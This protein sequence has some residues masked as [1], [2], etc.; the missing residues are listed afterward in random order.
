MYRKRFGLHDHPLP[1]DACGSSFYEGGDAFA[2]LRRVFHWLADEPGLAILTGDAGV[3]KTAALRHLCSTLP[4]PEHRVL[5]ICDTQV[6]ATAL[7][8]NL[9]VE[10]GLRPAH[11]RDALWRDLKRTMLQLVDEQNVIPMLILD[12]AQHLPDEFFADLAGFLNYAFDS[13][14]LLTVWL[15]GLPS[16][17]HRLAM[18]QHAA[19]ATRIVSANRIPARTDREDFFAMIE[20]AMAAAGAT[21]R[22]LSDPALELLWRA[23]RGLPR[24]AAKILRS[25]L[26]LAH[27]RDHS[28]VDDSLVNAAIDD[29][30]LEH[31][32]TAPTPP[33]APGQKSRRKTETSSRR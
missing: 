25:S 1:R 20:S 22:L 30:A 6:S 18:R 12:E 15:V 3:G 11:R 8:R 4:R 33:P 13:R 10:L 31:P 17:D 29:L 32:T 9:A 28:F 7:Y 27:E 23:S 2:R 21:T 19:L 14:D 26:M 5:Y 16:L 24:L